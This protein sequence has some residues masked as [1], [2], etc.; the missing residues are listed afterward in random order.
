[1]FRSKKGSPPII[2]QTGQDRIDRADAED[3]EIER[4]APR[5]PLPAP[6]RAYAASAPSY[7]V[8]RRGFELPPAVGRG[9]TA[10][11]AVREKTLTVGRDVQLR[12]EIIACE[13]LVVEGRVDITVHS[14]HHVQ[15]GESGVFRGTFDVAE[16]D[17][18]GDLEGEITV[19]ERL[20]VRASGK[21]RGRIR[22]RHIVIEAG[23]LIIG[24]V[25]ELDNGNKMRGKPADD[26][27][28]ATTYGE[29]PP[30]GGQ[31]PPLEAETMIAPID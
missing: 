29:N 24:D 16:A 19:R 26:D 22:Y 11:G 3:A 23:G 6:V 28:R 14:C 27:A 10:A 7:E 25:G 21:I 20:T 1:M 13:R 9:A 31:K 18:A 2:E 8:S 12:G 30:G 5:R 4:A 17:I 15:V